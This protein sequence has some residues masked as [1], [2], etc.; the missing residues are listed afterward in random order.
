MKVVH[1]MLRR[2]DA[3]GQLIYPLELGEEDYQGTGSFF[4][5]GI[6]QEDVDE[7]YIFYAMLDE[8]LLSIPLRRLGSSYMFEADVGRI[9]RFRFRATTIGVPATYGGAYSGGF[10]SFGEDGAKLVRQLAPSDH[11]DLEDAARRFGFYF[12]GYSPSLMEEPEPAF[13]EGPTPLDD[14]SFWKVSRGL[15]KA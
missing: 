8:L 7:A 11:R 15:K 3:L 5:D 14:A 2:P 13:P 12:I 10:G 9:G 6:G 4:F 1:Y